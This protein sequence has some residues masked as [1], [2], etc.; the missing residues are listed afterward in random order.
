MT[1]QK[2]GKYGYYYLAKTLVNKLVC[3]VCQLIIS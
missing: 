1:L 2:E 3:A